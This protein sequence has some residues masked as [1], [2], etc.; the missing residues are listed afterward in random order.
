M[1][2]LSMMA[3]NVMQRAAP[4]VGTMRQMGQMAEEL[5]GIGKLIRTYNGGGN[6]MDALE[7]MGRNNPK[8]AQFAQTLRG[9]SEAEMKNAAEEL[10]QKKGIDL[11][12]LSALIH[13]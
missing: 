3:N 12:Q 10:A 6:V 1:S 8:I 13:K 11:N 4:M 2:F 7:A 5:D 9:K